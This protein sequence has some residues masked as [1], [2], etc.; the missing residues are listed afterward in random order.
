MGKVTKITRAQAKA[1][2]QAPRVRL[3]KHIDMSKA[4]KGCKRCNGR[5]IRGYKQ[6]KMPGGKMQRAPV[7]CRCVSRAGGV[8][9]DALDGII[10]QMKKDLYDGV[11]AKNLAKDIMAM[12]M[13][14]RMR[15]FKQ[16]HDD[17]ENP[18]KSQQ[19]KDAIG[20]TLKILCL[21]T[22]N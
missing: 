8:K 17:L 9:P 18:E 12:T 1:T 20:E 4:D 7:I 2:A 19:A 11:F 13:E 16:L 22:N 15:V 6:F 14:Q 3:A 21:S 5:G 10:E